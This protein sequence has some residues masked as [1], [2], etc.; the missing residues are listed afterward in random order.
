MASFHGS[1]VTEHPARPGAVKAAIIVFNGG[2]DP[3]VKPEHIEAFK[4]E[5]KAAGAD[6]TFISYAGARHSFTNPEADVY[7]KRFNLPL[8]Y[9]P[10][11]DRQSWHTLQQFL[12]RVFR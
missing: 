6:F 4:R 5:M 9:D 3:F 12:K 7:G 1:L 8:A 10:E 2:D 11:A